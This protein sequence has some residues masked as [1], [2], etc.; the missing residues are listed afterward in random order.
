MK[1]APIKILKRR[2][3]SRSIL[4][5]RYNHWHPCPS[6]TD[7]GGLTWHPLFLPDILNSLGIVLS[8]LIHVRTHPFSSLAG[9]LS[10]GW[11][12]AC[13][14]FI[15]AAAGG[16]RAEEVG[17]RLEMY[18]LR[19]PRCRRSLPPRE[20]EPQCGSVPS[21]VLEA[22]GCHL[23]SSTCLSLPG[24]GWNPFPGLLGY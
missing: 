3:P 18:G 5:R 14:P 12:T 10:Y 24:R 16:G 19:I 9:S 2:I 7:K 13:F 21:L 6:R 4:L 8:R 11:T 1:L 22:V 23:F 15:P 20:A 17:H